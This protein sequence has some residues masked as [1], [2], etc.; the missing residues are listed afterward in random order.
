MNSTLFD[1]ILEDAKKVALSEKE[2]TEKQIQ[3][4]KLESKQ[5]LEKA[6][7]K[8]QSSFDSQKQAIYAHFESQMASYQ[9]HAL[10]K[11]QSALFDEVNKALEVEIKNICKHPSY[12][13]MLKNWIVEALVSLD[14]PQVV[15]SC[16]STDPVT[17]TLLKECSLEAQ[18][19]TGKAYEIT[20]GFTNL[21][22]NGVILSSPDQRVSFNNL[23]SS[24]LRRYKTE[25]NDLVE[26]Y[27]CKTE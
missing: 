23:V 17:E 6:L 19:H 4:L 8:E 24:R 5:R 20:L 27:A 25:I 16:S 7:E 3:A 18:K 10:L 15:L 21:N 1:G 2:N 26:G 22:E 14:L 9:R 13:Q 11:K 12:S